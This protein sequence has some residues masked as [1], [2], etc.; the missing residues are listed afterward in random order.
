[1]KVSH[2]LPTDSMKHTR[3]LR[4]QPGQRRTMHRIVSTAAAAAMLPYS[5]RCNT[6]VMGAQG[7][8]FSA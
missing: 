4:D 6:R 1:M 5:K 7:N 8:Q 3:H 2:S